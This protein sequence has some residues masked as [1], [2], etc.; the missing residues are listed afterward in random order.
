MSE[1]V[2]LALMH[3]AMAIGSY[4]VAAG[5]LSELGGGGMGWSRLKGGRKTEEYCLDDQMACL[6]A[7]VE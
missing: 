3:V 6:A 4:S 1:P 2:G 7:Y 5:G